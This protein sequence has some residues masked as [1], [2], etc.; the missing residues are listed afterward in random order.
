MKIRFKKDSKTKFGCHYRCVIS[1]CFGRLL[2]NLEITKF[3]QKSG[4][5]SHEPDL[6]Y[7][8]K[9]NFRQK[10]LTEIQNDPTK[11]VK[12]IYDDQVKLNSEIENLPK[13][14]K[15]S[16]GL[17]KKTQSTFAKNSENLK[18]C[19]DGMWSKTSDNQDFVLH[20]DV[21]L[22]IFCSLK[23]QQF[24][25]KSQKILCDGTFKTAPKPFRQI[26]T[27]FSVVQD[28]WSNIGVIGRKLY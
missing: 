15:I 14:H 5:H 8:E 24:L 23:N 4:N 26:Y 7:N 20:Q 2:T 13:Y 25:Q 6:M 21:G 28:Y 1:N 11:P 10:N 18:E 22:V 12:M 27:K 3:I 16:S 17:L 9:E 19:E